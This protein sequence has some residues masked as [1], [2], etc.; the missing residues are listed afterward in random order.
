VGEPFGP[1]ET[2][3]VRWTQELTLEGL[4][5]LVRSRSYFI[6]KQ[7]DE[8]VAV[9]ESVR[10]LVAEHP[11]LAGRDTIEMPYITECYRTELPDVAG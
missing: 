11:A 1:L 7:P 10:R 6:T 8:Q 9:L 2:F 5:D 3:E 4:L